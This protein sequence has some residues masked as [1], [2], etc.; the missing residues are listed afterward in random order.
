YGRF[1]YK[2]QR[3]FWDRAIAEDLVTEIKDAV[4]FYHGVDKP[5]ASRRAAELR[6]TDVEYTNHLFDETKAFKQREDEMRRRDE[7]SEK[8]RKRLKAEVEKRNAD[9]V[10]RAA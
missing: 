6:L 5:T 8:R 1:D 3:A 9:P 10:A 2:A 4:E 7:E